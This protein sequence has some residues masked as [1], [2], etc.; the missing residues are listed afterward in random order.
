MGRSPSFGSTAC[1]YSLLAEVM[2]YS[3]S[4]SLRLRV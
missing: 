4:L 1:D 2:P 3:D